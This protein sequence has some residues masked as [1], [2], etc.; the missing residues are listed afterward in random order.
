MTSTVSAL[1]YDAAHGAFAVLQ[2]IST[3]PDGFAG[4]NSTAEVRVHPSGKF[5]YVSNRGH[6]SIA[7]FAVDRETGK[8]TPLGHESTRGKIPRNF[9]LDPSGNY[10]L[11]ANQDSD[12][13]VVFRVDEESGRLTA[14][15]SEVKVGAP[16][17]VRFVALESAPQ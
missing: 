17:C 8:L 12:N 11:A 13:V 10:L 15:G 1:K 3:L 16:V 4:E 5:V 9:N 6:N 7:M 14:T 2:T